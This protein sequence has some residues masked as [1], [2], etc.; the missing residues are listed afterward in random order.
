VCNLAA[1][2]MR[3]LTVKF[4]DSTYTNRDC[5]QQPTDII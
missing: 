4:V 3:L 1:F 2:I 5:N